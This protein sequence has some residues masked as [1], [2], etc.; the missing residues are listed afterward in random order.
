MKN[1]DRL[2]EPGDELRRDAEIIDQHLRQI[3]RMVLRA[4]V[5]DE[6]EVGLTA[7][8]LQAMTMLAESLRE[9]RDGMTIRELSERMGLAQSTVSSLVERLERKQLVRRFVDSSDRRYT[10]VV[11]TDAV[12]SYLEQMGPRGRSS[13]LAIALEAA[14]EKERQTVLD[15]L[16]ILHRFLAAVSEEAHQ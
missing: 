14:T 9:N 15:G 6:R 13:P 1:E 5:A 3:R 4:F 7:P 16:A 10:R 8:Q 12:K 11:L 2:E